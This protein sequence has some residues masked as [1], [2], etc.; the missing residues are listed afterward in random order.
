[1]L[2][3][4]FAAIRAR[5]EG[6]EA[7][8]LIGSRAFVAYAY[9]DVQPIPEGTRFYHVAASAEA[10][11]REFAADFA[12]TGDL[13]PTLNAIAASLSPLSDA[14]RAKTRL[15]TLATDKAQRAASIRSKIE[16][17]FDERPLR[18]D[19]AVLAVLGALPPDTLIANDS[20]ATFGA[21]Q[22]IMQ[23]SPGLYFFAR[24]GVLGC[25][26]PAAVGASLAHDGPVA[27]FVG[28]GGAMYSPQALWS[29]A[30]YKMRTI[31]FIFNNRRYNVLMNVAKDLGT[32]NALAGRFVGMDLIE[33]AVD[34]QALAKSMG[35]PSC[36]AEG[37]L[38]IAAA[39]KTALERN[40][41]T[42]IEIPI[43]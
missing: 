8:L 23:T 27:C 37:P 2:K 19:A 28:D 30:H 35:V 29:A 33:P 42:L 21:V 16:A 39:T 41:P 13:A 4:D 32:K 3:P 9:R 26:M 43:A 36:C 7:V 12:V 6:V 18:A 24:G 10:I 17:T 1:M 22:E 25:A 40:G 5:L 34:F 38:E 11:G 15:A 20:A 14:K 31:F